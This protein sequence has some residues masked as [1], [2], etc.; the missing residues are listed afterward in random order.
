MSMQSLDS[1]LMT[2]WERSGGVHLD[3]RAQGLLLERWNEIPCEPTPIDF[4]VPVVPYRGAQRISISGSVQGLPKVPCAVSCEVSPDDVLGVSVRP[5]ADASVRMLGRPLLGYS[6]PSQQP[7][8]YYGDPNSLD[9]AL[10]GFSVFVTRLGDAAMYGVTE[11]GGLRALDG[12]SSNDVGAFTAVCV[13][14]FLR[15][16]K[17][18]ESEQAGE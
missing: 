5:A 13:V 12:V 4:N 11:R 15:R 9:R 16:L 3:A 17:L 8:G 2:D 1:R 7:N 14:E 6:N 10:C 18:R